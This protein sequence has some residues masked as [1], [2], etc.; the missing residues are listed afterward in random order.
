MKQRPWKLFWNNT[1]LPLEINF[2]G[3]KCPESNC[4][5]GGQNCPFLVFPID[6]EDASDENFGSSF[7]EDPC[8]KEFLPIG[9]RQTINLKE[10][11]S[12]SFCRRLKTAWEESLRRQKLPLKKVRLDAESHIVRWIFSEK[13]T[14][15][16]AKKVDDSDDDDNANDD[17][18]ALS[19]CRSPGSPGSPWKAGSAGREPGPPWAI[20]PT[21]RAALAHAHTVSPILAKWG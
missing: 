2:V 12:S 20:W 18:F 8:Q 11:H 3:A 19:T 21:W 9:G 17:D 1:K 10:T 7:E 13:K 14:K 6:L 16:Q 4:A 15:L 5:R